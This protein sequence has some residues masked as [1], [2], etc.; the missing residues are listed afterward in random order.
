MKKIFFT[1]VLLLSFT[2]ITLAQTE[3]APQPSD[4]LKPKAG[5]VE[6]YGSMEEFTEKNPNYLTHLTVFVITQEVYAYIQKIQEETDEEAKILVY[7]GN[8]SIR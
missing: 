8:G 2:G 6:F 1:I 3:A 5:Q 4:S 7:T